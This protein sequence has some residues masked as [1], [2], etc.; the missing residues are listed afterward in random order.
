MIKYG[1]FNGSSSTMLRR[2]KAPKFGF[3]ERLPI[4]SV[5]MYWFYA[6]GNGV[7]LIIWIKY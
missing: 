3:D 1:Y 6:L 4:V 7:K 2:S 5:W